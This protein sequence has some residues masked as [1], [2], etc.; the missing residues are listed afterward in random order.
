MK[1]LILLLFLNSL[2]FFRLSASVYDPPTEPPADTSEVNKAHSLH[3]TVVKEERY[4]KSLDE[5]MAVTLP[6]GIQ[7][8]IGN[9]E[10]I[11]VLETM[12]FTPK[13][14]T[15]TAYMSSEVPKS[16]K[17]IALKGK[18]INFAPEGFTSG[19]RLELLENVDIPLGEN[20]T[21]VV[22]GEESK[23]FVEWDCKGYK[24]MGL[25]GDIE[26]SRKMLLPE[27]ADGKIIKDKNVKVKAGFETQIEG[28][29]D[30]LVE[31]SISAFQL[32]DL[33][34]FSFLVNS[35]VFD[36]SELANSPSMVFPQAYQS[37]DFID[38]DKKMWKG[39]FL[40]DMIVKL[41]G[42][43]SKDTVQ[44]STIE[45]HNMIIDNM[46]ISGFFSAKNVIP[47]GEAEIGKWPF[48]LDEISTEIAKNQLVS[49]GFKG[50][51]I[52]PPLSD[53]ATLNYN[54]FID[55]N[56]NYNFLV[57]TNDSLDMDMWAAKLHLNP[58]SYIDIS[59]VDGKFKPKAVLNGNLSVKT[60]KIELAD[61]DFEELTIKTDAP[62]IKAEKFSFGSEFAQQ[63]LGKFPIAVTD[64]GMVN[65]DDRTGLKFNLKLN[66]VKENTG[67]FTGET[68]LTLFAKSYEENNRQ[69]WKYDGFEVSK[70]AIDIDGGAFKLKGSAEWYKEDPVYGNGFSGNLEAD[71]KALTKVS[72]TALFG[73]INGM[74]YF[75]ADAMVNLNK[76]VPIFTGLNLYGMGGGIYHHM[77]QLGWEEKATGTIGKTAS[78]IIYKPDES[79][80]M[81]FKATVN[82][83]LISKTAF[84]SDLTFEMVFNKNAGV[85]RILFM[86]NGYFMT[87]PQEGK[88]SVLKDK[89]KD[90]AKGKDPNVVANK[91][92]S[93]RSNLYAFVNLD[94][95]FE[96]DVMH[97]NLG[98][99]INLPGGV[100][101]GV[102]P[103]GKAGEAVMHFAKNEWY[104]HIGTPTNR[105]GV[106]ALKFAELNA[107]FMM[108]TTIPASPP[109]PA[110]VTD[111]LGNINLDYMSFENSLASGKGIGF[112]A[113]LQ[114]NTGNKTFK[115]FYAE[116]D[117]GAGFDV[118]LK[119]YGNVN[120]KGLSEPLGINGW[121]ANG[122]VWAYLEGAIGIRVDWRFIHGNYEILKVGAAAVLQAK[123]PNPFWMHGIIGGRYSIL[124]GLVSGNCRFDLTIGEECEMEGVNSPVQGM[125]VIAE[126]TPN[127]GASDVNVFNA[128]QAVFNMPIDKTFNLADMEGND[129]SFKIVLDK[130]K[131]LD[132]K[133]PLQGDLE[134][135]AEKDVV[136]FNAFEILPPQK[137]LTLEVQ[138]SFKEKKNGS[139]KTV[140]ANGK[141][142]TESLKTTFTT[143]EAPKYIPIS[144]VAYSYPLPM[145]FNYYQNET[146]IGYIQ[147]KK[148]QA[149]LFNPG[150]EWKQIGRFTDKNGNKHQFNFNY[151]ASQKKVNFKRPGN[152]QNNTIYS[153]EL[154]NVPV[155]KH[156]E[157]DKNVITKID[158]KDLKIKGQNTENTSTLEIKTK[159]AEGSINIL[160]EKSIFKTHFRTSKFNTLSDKLNAFERRIY[161]KDYIIP[162]VQ[163]LYIFYY[164]NEFFAKEE[165][166]WSNI[167]PLIQFQA[168]NDN[169]WYNKIV[170]PLIY[171]GYPY[172][173]LTIK[174]RQ[175]DDYGIPPN[176][177]ITIYQYPY[178]ISLTEEHLQTGVPN[179]NSDFVAFKYGLSSPM[180][181]DYHDLLDQAANKYRL[182]EAPSRIRYLFNNNFTSIYKGYYKSNV[183]YVLPGTNQITNS[184]EIIFYSPVGTE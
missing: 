12:K 148:G 78:G 181:Y 142:V 137:Q 93:A 9:T 74:R 144:N 76:G 33:K 1:F 42:N 13:G 110:K 92:N 27:G 153:F 104:I 168:I 86:G 111:I 89:C 70:I 170:Y 61:V 64:I 19:A 131:I 119:N 57:E 118:M 75:Y 3:E 49:C 95:D 5:V 26:F 52:V 108:G 43:L 51:I 147:L 77:S 38:D 99:Y 165:T 71:F 126:A 156:T 20:M 98:T 179:L 146:D 40:K 162:R 16:E 134:W 84:N 53:T 128:A 164:G 48:S 139:W 44:R 18:D 10:N 173:G 41:P 169:K 114:F 160:D 21:M 171:K 54:A 4:I 112:G 91:D 129:L 141:K 45:A 152:L 161:F 136:A 81:G 180:Y 36:Y 151:V 37:S 149:Y 124:G 69:R 158:K 31:V 22:K 154:V 120:C 7:K 28:W 30:L 97:G 127:D 87:P 121:Y 29:D 32:K 100:L 138:V 182:A 46:G 172:N 102:G 125:Q 159:D 15:L 72:V 113:G 62:Y 68:G 88:L 8:T 117:A 83:G 63:K 60:K 133:I 135:N 56:N 55:L 176:N 79:T 145:M 155:K 157:I 65:I 143:G 140:M 116:F 67:G 24:S 122:Q 184:T 59:V 101:T 23:T 163:D 123:L 150:A 25:Q 35:A 106:K 82:V 39:F 167:S 174:H 58:N 2:F 47:K 90:I 166:V 85:N 105:F 94:F 103:G 109:P 11:I 183:K 132:G 50:T 96:N 34:D 73:N 66:L 175:T 177:P 6:V 80:F 107:Y 14:A 178:E 115:P 130:F 17:R